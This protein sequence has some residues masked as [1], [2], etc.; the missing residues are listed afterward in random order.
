[1]YPIGNNMMGGPLG[2]SSHS[3]SSFSDSGNLILCIFW[4]H[5]I[6]MI[7][8]K[9]LMTPY[10][11]TF[12]GSQSHTRYLS[13]SQSLKGH[14]GMMQVHMSPPTIYGVY[15]TP[16]WMIVSGSDSSPAPLLAMLQ[17]GTLSYHT[18]QSN[19]WCHGNGIFKAL[20]ASYPLRNRNETPCYLMTRHLH[21]HL[22]SHTWMDT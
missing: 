3:S 2:P 9:W 18:H 16:W 13:T 5:L 15:W 11:I 19:L 21:P 8:I 17:S 4:Q 20:S 6:S 22:W 1:M 7:C 12:I 14:K 10:I